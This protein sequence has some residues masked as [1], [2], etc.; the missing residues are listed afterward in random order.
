MYK[1]G[2]RALALLLTAALSAGTLGG[3]PLTAAA[4]EPAPEDAYVLRYEG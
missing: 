2:K 3:L 1:Y 4:Q